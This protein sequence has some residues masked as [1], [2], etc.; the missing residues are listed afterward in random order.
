MDMDIKNIW[1]PS[2]S[3]WN[4]FWLNC[5]YSTFF[6]SR[7]WAE[8]WENYSRHKIIPDP[9]AITLSDGAQVLLPFSKEK[10]YKGI[11]SRHIS[12]PAGTFGGWLSN[13]HLDQR[14]QEVVLNFLRENYK[15]LIWRSNPYENYFSVSGYNSVIKDDTQSLDLS[16]GFDVVE[17]GFS[18]GNRRA[19]KE[20]L[21]TSVEI[22]TAENKQDWQEY[23]LVYR[24]SLERWGEQ[25][26]QVYDWNLFK[27]IMQLDSRYCR[28]WLARFRNT[29]I[30]GALCFYSPVQ[31]VYWHG[32]ALSDY[33]YLRPVNFLM[34]KIIQ[35]AVESTY[36]WFD[37]NPSGNLEGVKT[38]KRSFGA[39]SME[40]KVFTY[41]S[42]KIAML[43]SLQKMIR[44]TPR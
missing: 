36:K 18:Q 19:V 20:A 25:A 29:I 22:N 28:L 16:V 26:T 11:A 42:R 3:E 39:R 15:N 32:A 27:F 30:A 5:P 31:V 14:Q 34:N 10:I 33:F 4:D 24:D 7:Q 12:S 13:E 6:H 1:S 35:H 37:F 2:E 17:R 9:L 21:R 41:F 23:F 40:S 8:I 43:A 44:R 38:F